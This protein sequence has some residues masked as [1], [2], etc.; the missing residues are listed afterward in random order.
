M[1][2][3]P[4]TAYTMHFYL[5]IDLWTQ[6]R[7]FALTATTRAELDDAIG[8]FTLLHDAFASWKVSNLQARHQQSFLTMITDSILWVEARRDNGDVAAAEH[9]LAEAGD[10]VYAE[11]LRLYDD[12]IRRQ[13]ADETK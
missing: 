9:D 11:L 3:E 12:A 1:S 6:V 7:D 5:A 2:E 8:R 4:N 13:A 10:G